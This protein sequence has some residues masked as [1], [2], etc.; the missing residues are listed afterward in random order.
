MKKAILTLALMIAA[1]ANAKKVDG[2]EYMV[3]KGEEALKDQGINQ[4]DDVTDPAQGFLVTLPEGYALQ[5]VDVQG[6]GSTLAPLS[7]AATRTLFQYPELAQLINEMSEVAADGAS[8][9]YYGYT[10]GLP[11]DQTL[12]I[13]CNKRKATPKHVSD[14]LFTTMGEILTGG[15]INLTEEKVK[16]LSAIAKPQFLELIGKGP[17]K[18]CSA[19]VGGGMSIGNIDLFIGPEYTFFTEIGYED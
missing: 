6:N 19:T 8:L 5:N 14:H 13:E 10:E 11:T 18:A 17:F 4:Y 9:E 7:Q 15:G 12:K 2:V 16:E 3:V 1:N